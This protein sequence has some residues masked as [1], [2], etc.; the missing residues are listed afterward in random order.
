VLEKVP[1]VIQFIYFQT[2]IE[3]NQNYMHLRL[4][5]Y[6][7][8]TRAFISIQ[9]LHGIG[10]TYRQIEK[11]AEFSLRKAKS[12]RMRRICL[13]FATVCAV[14]ASKLLPHAPHTLA[15]C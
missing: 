10:Q 5:I 8:K 12:Y 14:Y 9:I 13:Q 3:E 15:Q 11:F 4:N 7:E 2:T 6:D 1:T